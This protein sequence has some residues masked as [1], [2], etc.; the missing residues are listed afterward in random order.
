MF[1]PWTRIY[2]RSRKQVRAS[3]TKIPNRDFPR[4]APAT[5]ETPNNSSKTRAFRPR[6]V[7]FFGLWGVLGYYGYAQLQEKQDDDGFYKYK[8]IAKEPVSSTASVFY[9][10]PKDR[11]IDHDFEVYRDAWKECVWNVYFKQPQLQIIRAYTPLPPQDTSEQNEQLR[12]LIRRDEHGEV[13]RYLHGLPVGTDIG[14]RGP[15]MEYRVSPEAK[16]VTFFAGG[17]GIAT[18]LQFAYAMFDGQNQPSKV[19]NVA[20]QSKKLHILWANRKREDCVGGVSD[21]AARSIPEKSLGWLSSSSAPGSMANTRS[22]ESTEQ[23]I[24]VRELERLKKRYP[25]Q[26]TVEYFV[27]EESTYITEETIVQALAGFDATAPANKAFKSTIEQQI[28]ISGPEGFISYIAGPKEWKNGREDQ[29]RLGSLIAQALA[30]QPC[31]VKV[32]KI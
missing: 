15:N 25:G 13:S 9:L 3:S 17:T 21:I 31:N 24:V 10:K 18:A 16:R 27:D 19:E 23:G 12:F 6:H 29:G 26:I 2:L 22:Q 32:Q 5:P 14:L 1:K 11:K 7:I 8:L 30:K 4:Q 20:A 28:I